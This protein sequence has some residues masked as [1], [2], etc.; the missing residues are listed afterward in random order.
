M[1]D[2]EGANPY[3]AP[4]GFFSSSQPS[5][6]SSEADAGITPKIVEMLAKTQPWVRFLSV[7]GFIGFALTMVMALGVL[8]VGVSR[9]DFGMVFISVLNAIFGL[10]YLFPSVYLSRFA[11]DIQRLRSTL[12]VQDLEEALESQKSFWRFAGI[13]TLFTVV[14]SI[15][16]LAIIAAS[17]AASWET[18]GGPVPVRR[19]S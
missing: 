19:S 4:S 9:T 3:Q 17:G 5:Y 1:S 6:F 2:P 11:S 13:A 18:P 14:L 15:G 10:V 12:R 7:L 16:V 8:M